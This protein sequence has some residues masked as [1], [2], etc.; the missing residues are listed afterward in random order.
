MPNYSS[1]KNW[2]RSKL[3]SG[4]AGNGAKHQS[5][6]KTSSWPPKSD[7]S[8]HQKKSD[9]VTYTDAFHKPDLRSRQ[10]SLCTKRIFQYAHSESVYSEFLS[11]KTNKNS[12]SRIISCYTL[13]GYVANVFKD[14]C[15]KLQVP[16]NSYNQRLYSNCSN[17]AN[18][19]E[20]D[21]PLGI[22]PSSHIRSG[23][24]SHHWGSINL[25]RALLSD[26][27]E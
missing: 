13:K 26:A 9:L 6:G 14:T 24:T 15:I 17:P 11:K 4:S 19:N 16:F 25:F 23:H 3:P 21:E 18:E 20:L 10:S 27:L 8:D 12:F 5:I 1:Y 7:K 22:L 2:G